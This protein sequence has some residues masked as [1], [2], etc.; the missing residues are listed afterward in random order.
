MFLSTPASAAFKLRPNL[1]IVLFIILFV[2]IGFF[3]AGILKR[4]AVLP[5]DVLVQILVVADHIG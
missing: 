2:L 1:F 4:F 3:S 5:S